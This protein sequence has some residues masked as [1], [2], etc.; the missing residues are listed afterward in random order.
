VNCHHLAV[1]FNEQTARHTRRILR[2]RE[3]TASEI[4]HTL[5]KEVGAVDA[6]RLIEIEGL[7]QQMTDVE[8]VE[9]KYLLKSE[10]V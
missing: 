10:D 2:N 9:G 3:L 4:T 8:K 1:G 5:N 7:L 6:Y